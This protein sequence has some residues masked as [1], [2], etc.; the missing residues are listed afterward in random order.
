MTAEHRFDGGR[1]WVMDYRE[2]PSGHIVMT[3]KYVLEPSYQLAYANHTMRSKVWILTQ[4]EGEFFHDGKNQQVGAGDVLQIT[5]GKPHSIRAMT[6]MNWAEVQV[7]IG[8]F[9]DV[10]EQLSVPWCEME[11]RSEGVLL[12]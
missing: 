6:V 9:N 4:G 5:A 3:S 10:E 1:C 2:E 7:G 12:Q 11:L 8:G